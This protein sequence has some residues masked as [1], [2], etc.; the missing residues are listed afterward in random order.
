MKQCLLC[1]LSLTVM[2][3]WSGICMAD[4][5]VYP[6]WNEYEITFTPEHVGGFYEDEDNWYH[7]GWQEGTS[8]YY[9][10]YYSDANEQYSISSLNASVTVDQ[11]ASFYFRPDVNSYYKDVLKVYLDGTLQ[12][13]FNKDAHSKLYALSLTPGVHTI[14]WT[15]SNEDKITGMGIYDFGCI[16]TPQITVNLLEPGS[17]GTE[18]LYNVNHLKEVRDLKVIGRMNTEDW[19]K[20]KMLTNLHNLDLSEAI[21]DE[22][23][24]EAFK[25]K[26][27]MHQVTLPAMVKRIG[28]EAFR[29]SGVEIVNMPSALETVGDNAFYF[30]NIGEVNMPA[31]V[32]EIGSDAFY[33]CQNLR[34]ASLGESLTSI[35]SGTFNGSIHL[36]SVVIPD[37]VTEIQSNA[38][39]GC[40]S[41]V[42]LTLPQSLKTIG[43][44]TFRNCTDLKSVVIPDKTE[45]MGVEAF[46]WCSSL[47]SVVIS[48]S[49][50]EIAGGTFQG[51]DALQTV[52][53]NAATVAIPEHSSNYGDP[54]NLEKMPDITFQVPLFLVNQYKLHE[55]WYN[56]KD[57]VGL[58]M[59][60]VNPWI[61][62]DRLVLDSHC[63]FVGTPDVVMNYKDSQEREV[64]FKVLGDAE[65][66]IHNLTL[67]NFSQA[68]GY[69][70]WANFYPT[71]LLSNCSNVNISGDIALSYPM[72]SGLWYFMSLPFDAPVADIMTEVEGAQ[73]ALHT[74][75]GAGR[76][77]NGVSSEGSN[78]TKLDNGDVIPAGTGFI[79]Q[80]DQDTKV[81]FTSANTEAKQNILGNKDITLTLTEHASAIKSNSGWNMVGNPW[82]CYY[83]SHYINFTAPI[84]VWDYENR[85]YM[86]YSLSDDDYAIRPNEAI[87]VQCPEGSLNT[88]GFPIAGRQLNTEIQSMN[89]TAAPALNATRQ[90]IDLRISNG[91]IYDRTRVVLN[92]EATL[93]YDTQCDASKFMSMNNDTPQL[94]SRDEN[95][96]SYAI[97][98]RPESDGNVKLTYKAPKAGTY[99]I[100]MGRCD[101]AE[102]WLY[103]AVAEKWI[104]LKA[105]GA[106]T[107]TARAGKNAE[108]FTLSLKAVPAGIDMIKSDAEDAETEV[109][110]TIDGRRATEAQQGLFI[111]KKGSIIVK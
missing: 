65:L 56:G 51:C 21:T 9:F 83:N 95:G 103:D 76:A 77:A 109:L 98:E 55:Y 30:S 75:D 47:E 105:E 111:S 63:R 80:V 66:N 34:S 27:F 67:N 20:V 57:V 48:A 38:F 64:S 92:D 94:Y 102:A 99:T 1:G 18:I 2:S 82:Q 26:Q 41:L 12:Y 101:A 61:I 62:N 29:G 107:F 100:E 52:R 6:E 68:S 8:G 73:F 36:K 59:E 15:V 93:G 4:N 50:N 49:M 71:Q 23:I 5:Y 11:N 13:E 32:T 14:K 19:E 108:R 16:A 35:K 7:S 31:G 96:T 106:Y 54:I 58:P 84:T 33:I 39:D 91:E 81:S 97:N 85:T 22:V 72:V 60:D 17:L 42:D 86:A 110:Y 104:D 53:L 87:F 74:Y 46:L 90:I 89:P 43:R 70:D 78:W 69:W 45:M 3:L 28:N 37:V 10:S 40:S 24:D 25:D 79:I 44:E 88:I